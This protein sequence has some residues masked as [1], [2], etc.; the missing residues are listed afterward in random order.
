MKG[1]QKTV[2]AVGVVATTGLVGY[3]LISKARARPTYPPEL[4]E[5]FHRMGDVNRD[6]II[7]DKDIALLQA[8][9]G[10]TPETPNWNPD[11]DLNGDGE[12]DVRDI[13]ICATNQGLT[14][15]EWLKTKGYRKTR[16]AQKP[17]L[18]KGI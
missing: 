17:P 5:E 18:I 15:E 8:A 4:I 3:V 13:F 7:N 9:Y 16:T 1:W 2:L 11:C 12:V 10:S 14:F 6:G